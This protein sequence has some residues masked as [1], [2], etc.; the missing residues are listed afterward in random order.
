MIDF[1]F[2]PLEFQNRFDKAQCLM[3]QKNIDVL[4]LC[5]EAEIR[6]FTG[7]RTL[8]W[9]S[10]TRPW[11]LIVPQTGAP[12][13][14]IPEIGADLMA[15]TWIDNI[16]TWSSPHKEDDGISL[17][18]KTLS[19]YKTIGI[20]AG[21]ESHIRMPLLDFEYLKNSL[22][23][24]SFINAT[25][26][27][28]E[29]RQ[30][31]SDAEIQI[32]HNICKIASKS[33]ANAN[34]LFYEGITMAEIFKRFKIS[35]LE[36]GAEDVPYLVGGLD[37]NG[38]SDVISP[39]SS[40]KAKV[41]DILMLD[42]GSTL[43]G[44]FCDFDRNFAFGHASDEVK[45]G[46]EKLIRATNKAINFIQPDIN[47]AEVFE[48]LQNELNETSSNVGRYGHGLGI[49]LTETPSIIDFDQTV[50]KPNMVM[51]IEPS[52]QLKNGKILVHEENILITDSGA[53]LLSEPAP[54]ELPVII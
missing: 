7:F 27:I 28:D 11:Y 34:T 16:E 33:F 13:A 12:K 10:P 51:T 26:I 6:Y 17:L 19:Q 42:T 36:N 54:E 25:P 31:K 39:P 4:F 5:T 50:L 32:I 1:D 43:K 35:L 46:Y 24:Q 49:Q 40:K 37:Q 38:Y 8:F 21:R 48:L 44:Y 9:Q 18:I 2:T 3:H 53:V 30:I 41:G 45:Y 52:I 47:C 20:P 23:N 14:I 22:I 29:I 15:K